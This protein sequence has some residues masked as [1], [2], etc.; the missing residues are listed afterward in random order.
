MVAAPQTRRELRFAC[1][2]CGAC[3]NRSP[4]MLLSEAAALADIFVFRLMFRLYE[5]PRTLAGHLASGDEGAG[6][7]E[8]YYETKRLLAAFA[9]RKYP[10][11]RRQSGKSVDYVRYVAISALTLD[12]GAGACT[13]LGNGRCG[14]YARRPLA[15]RTVPFHYSRPEASAER[16]LE[17]FVA[18]P[19][20]G[21]DT[22][23]GAPIV[24]EAGRIVDPEARRARDE[25]IALAGQ[26]RPWAEAIVRR[27]KTGAGD[28]ALP[29]LRQIE[30]D[31][32]FGAT[33]VSMH[34]AWRIAAEAG[35]IGAAACR[36]LVAA[37]AALIESE[38]ASARWTSDAR[39]TLGEM[40]AEYLELL[41]D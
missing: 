36:T 2:S 21:C 29:S 1:T 38:L 4:E 15:C 31:A 12:A 40:R 30:A 33:T 41:G 26:D 14:I 22:G 17:A 16:E 7:G 35:L 27:L 13:A 23:A 25:A 10:A 20:F 6:S 11:R 3:C 18:T 9:A 24:L 19:G 34:I 32:P 39:E 37:Q 28:H 5:L 8:E